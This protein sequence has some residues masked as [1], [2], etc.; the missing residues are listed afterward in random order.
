M[1]SDNSALGE[2]VTFENTAGLQLDGILY[3]NK[4][5]RT[6]IVHIHG[7]FGNFYHNHFLRLM[8]KKYI[9]AGINFL[10][11]NLSTHD[12]ISE[13]VRCNENIEEWEYIGFS[14]MDFSTCI[15]DIAGAVKF[16][17]SFSDRIILQGHSMGCDR[18]LFYLIN[19]KLD[20]DFIL[21]SPT[22]GYQLHNTWL[23][24]ETVEEQITRLKKS[25][26]SDDDYELLP[27]K[28]YGIKQPDFAYEIP[29]TRKALLS[30]IDGPPFKNIRIDSPADFRLRQNSIIYMGGNDSYQ[31]W[32]PETIFKYF[33]DRIQYVQNIFIQN[34]DHNFSGFEN[35]VIEKIVVWVKKS[36]RRD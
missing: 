21:L 29:I 6:T 16:A 17:N 11:F 2:L 31:T 4:S 1:I 33:E 35:Y 28:E 24:P 32:K 10:S 14:V 22:D 18:V 26:S 5:Y 36:S 15:F 12:G 8:A 7:S 13:A 23:G 19:K 20:Y 34:G 30:I 3:H 9:E 25:N 27:G